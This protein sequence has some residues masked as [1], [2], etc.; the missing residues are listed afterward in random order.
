MKID[1]FKNVV[2]LEPWLPASVDAAPLL[3]KELESEVGPKHPL[4]Q[5]RA[6][7]VGHRCDDDVL[8]FL[9]DGPSPLAVVHLTY[10]NKPEQDPIWPSTVFYSSLEEWI[11]RCMKPDNAGWGK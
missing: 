8:F 1:D 3:I 10:A 4:F 6:I 2:W 11:E 7:A 5:K 9:P